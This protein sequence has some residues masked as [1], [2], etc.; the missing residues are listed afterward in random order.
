MKIGILG[1]TFDPIHNAHIELALSALSS[2][3]LDRVVFMPA[4]TPYFKNGVTPKVHR[5]NM[6]ELGIRGYDRFEYSDLELRQE[7]NTYTAETLKT[8]KG[9]HPEN[10]YYFL[11]GADCLEEII[12]W[13]TP[14]E[15]FRNAVIVGC[16]RRE[17]S[18]PSDPEASAAILRARWGAD[19]R[20]LEWKG[21]DVSSTKIREAVKS[22]D[23]AVPV[24]ASVLAYIREN[25]IYSPAPNIEQ[26]S[27]RLQKELTSHRYAHTLGVADT[28]VKLAEHYHLDKE[29]AYLAG[30]LHDC[31]KPYGSALGHAGIGA[32]LA[33]FYYGV[34]DPEILS[35]IA[36][37]TVGKPDMTMLEKVIF[38]ADMIEPGRDRAE[39]LPELRK[40][41]YEDLDRC[42][43]RILET[44]HEYLA[45]NGISIDDT[46]KR[47]YNYYKEVQYGKSGTDRSDRL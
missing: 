10:T 28:A 24:P 11:M 46:S 26:V 20:I 33:E 31:G 36:C 14:E 19:V 27:S 25:G 34:R 8:L 42:V 40:L 5:G 47:V 6:V 9:Q 38:I 22:G 21:P 32:K 3:S 2:L 43:F 18:D 39:S 29:R 44:V 13:R 1:G 16:A 30:L 7:G 17:G 35:A 37:H 41:A 12:T 15:I 45:E 23:Y 4:G